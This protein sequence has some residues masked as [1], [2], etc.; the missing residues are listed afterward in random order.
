MVLLVKK[1]SKLPIPVAKP[2]NMV[3]PNAKRIS[4]HV[5]SPIVIEFDKAKIIRI[6]DASYNAGVF[7]PFAS[8]SQ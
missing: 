8:P 7:L 2:A 6:F 4:F 1:V 5:N 3:S